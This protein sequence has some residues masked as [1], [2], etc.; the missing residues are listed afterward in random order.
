MR[1]TYLQVAKL[2]LDA[3]FRGQDA[4]TVVAIAKGESDFETTATN[5]NHATG[6]HSYGLLQ[7]NMHNNLGPERRAKYNLPNNEALFDPATNFRVGFALYKAQGNKFTDWSVYTSR[8]Y[9]AYM[10]GATIAVRQVQNGVIPPAPGKL[11]DGPNILPENLPE[12]PGM[13]DFAAIAQA[14]KGF[15]EFV[16]N[17]ENWLRVAAVT[18]GA[19][20]LIVGIFL[21]MSDTLVG[22]LLKRVGKATKVAKAVT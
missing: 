11:P 9:L 12:V 15:S 1:L 4:I 10:S 13:S 8:A 22:Q 18:G 5:F 14:A 2:A 6:D 16:T 3:G 7:I 19:V 17:R 20:L 21:I